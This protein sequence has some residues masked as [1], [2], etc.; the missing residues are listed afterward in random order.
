DD[1]DKDDTRSDAP[2]SEYRTRILTERQ[3]RQRETK[4]RK[5]AIR[6]LI[7]DLRNPLRKKKKHQSTS[8]DIIVDGLQPSHSFRNAKAGGPW[9]PRNIRTMQRY[10]A[11]PNQDRIDYMER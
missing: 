5:G 1:E 2:A 4:R 9:A 7:E 3:R 6:S 11:G 8:A 10:H